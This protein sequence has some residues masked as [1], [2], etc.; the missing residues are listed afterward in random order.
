MVGTNDPA[1]KKP[2]AKIANVCQFLVQ[3]ALL[4]AEK[5]TLSSIPPREDDQVNMERLDKINEHY[6][7]IADRKRNVTFVKH[8]KNVKYQDSSV[9]T[10]MM[11]TVDVLH[12]S[13]KGTQKLIDNL[14]LGDVARPTIGK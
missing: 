8:N 9:D 14:G 6:S 4:R 10:S 2:A 7:N 3:K 1:M 13:A 12:L 5:V 11:L